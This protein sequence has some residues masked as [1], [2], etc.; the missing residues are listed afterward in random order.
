MYLVLVAAP[1]IDPI[2]VFWGTHAECR[3]AAKQIVADHLYSIDS[4]V[5]AL[6]MANDW[7]IM[8]LAMLIAQF[9]MAHFKQ[10]LHELLQRRPTLETVALSFL[11]VVGWIS[12]FEACGANIPEGYLFAAIGFAGMVEALNLKL[13]APCEKEPA[14]IRIISSNSKARSSKP[15]V[16]K[17]REIARARSQIMQ[18]ITASLDDQSSDLAVGAAQRAQLADNS[19]IR[20]TNSCSSCQPE[21]HENFAIGLGY[22][23]LASDVLELGSHSYQF[24]KLPIDSEEMPLFSEA[25]GPA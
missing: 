3:Q 9:A 6:A 8:V 15:K 12:L 19:S 18:S 25:Y 17:H 21:V 2:N 22:G 4:V 16:P 5:A 10:P 1:V 13:L 14:P 24:G 23:E 20:A 7:R 11:F